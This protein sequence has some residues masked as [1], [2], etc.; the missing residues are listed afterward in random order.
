[1]FIRWDELPTDTVIP[2]DAALN[3]LRDVS[4]AVVRN[5]DIRAIRRS[6]MREQAVRIM[7]QRERIA[8]GLVRDRRPVCYF[9][10][11]RTAIGLRAYSQYF[12]GNLCGALH[13]LLRM[14]VFPFL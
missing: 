9:E 8:R 1:M 13:D 2:I 6:Q 7:L 10:I 14:S 4:N 3:D 12:G 11:A 5:R